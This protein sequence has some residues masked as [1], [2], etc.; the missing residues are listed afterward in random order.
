M[1]PHDIVGR[2]RLLDLFAGCGGLS[3]GFES[4]GFEVA[5]AVDNWPEALAVYRR[6]FRHR[7]VEL[8]LGDVDLASS[9]LRECAAEVDGIIGGPP[10]QDFS[11]AGRRVE[12]GRADLTE[13]FAQLVATFLPSFFVMENVERAAKAAAPRR[14]VALLEAH[15]YCVARIVLDASR[16]G[17]PQRRKRLFTI[18][19]LHPGSTRAAMGALTGNLAAAPMTLRDYF[20]SALDVDH[21]YRHPRSYARR[22]VFSVDEPSPTVRGVNRP[23]P[24][25]YPGHPGDTA[26]LTAGLRALTTAERAMVQTFPPDFWFGATKTAAEQMIGNAVPVKLAQYVAE[27]VRQGLASAQRACA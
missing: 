18:G 21:Y 20:G 6:N 2:P 11:S 27:A 26:P 19:F 4:A 5:L 10:C 17:V 7:A 9:A 25:G 13:K 22:A 16:C 1:A 3:L 8:D 24:R 15:G 23:V 12:A 14:A